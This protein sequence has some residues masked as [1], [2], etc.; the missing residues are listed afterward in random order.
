MILL[1]RPG[2]H[3]SAHVDHC[4]RLLQSTTKQ[5]LVTMNRQLPFRCKAD[6]AGKLTARN[7]HLYSSGINGSELTKS[8][9][10]VTGRRGAALQ[11]G[12]SGGARSMNTDRAAGYYEATPPSGA[13]GDVG[14]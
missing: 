9:L 3:R 14:I 12:R 2:A 13:G 4:L 7:V 1:M 11:D 8:L 10:A 5:T 6:V